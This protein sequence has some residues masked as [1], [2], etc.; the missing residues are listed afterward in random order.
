[1][2]KTLSL[3]VCFLLCI[4]L[5]LSVKTNFWKSHNAYLEQQPPSDTPKI[6]AQGLLA[7]TGIALDRVTF[8]NNGKEFYY[9]YAPHWFDSK[10]AKIKYFKYI[11]G[12]WNG[13]TVLNEGFYAPSFSANGRTLFFIGGGE[14]GVVWQSK[15]IESKWTV[16]TEYI[17]RNYGVYD[18][19]TTK[20]GKMYVGSN[21]MQGNRNKGF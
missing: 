2:E 4:G 18:F 3:T 20:S 5:Q 11:S 17:R 8:S 10:G 15:R 1:M 13:P 14:S 9:C 12:K 19:M 7:D 16:P 21:G 6:F